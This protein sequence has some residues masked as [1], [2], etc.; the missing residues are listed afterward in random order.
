MAITQAIC[1][2]RSQPRI[3]GPLYLG[4][5]TM[6]SPSRRNALPRSARGNGVETFIQRDPAT[7]PHR[8]FRAPSSSTITAA[9]TPLADGIV[10]TP[11][12]NPPADGGFKYNPPNGGPAE[13]AIP[14]GSRI[15]PTNCCAQA[16]PNPARAAS[17]THSRPP[18]LSNRFPAAICRRFRPKPRP[19]RHPRRQCRSAVDPLGGASLGLLGAHQR[20]LRPRNRSRQSQ[21]RPDLQLHDGGSRRQNPH[22]L[23]H[24]PTPWP[25]SSS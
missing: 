5:D 12:H 16:G 15:A 3:D 2:Y 6:P 17:P 4:K 19:R 14:N 22:G 13:T 21:N 8:S 1:E 25:A 10:I 9:K 20:S 24:R 7:P 18:P 23:L 11:S